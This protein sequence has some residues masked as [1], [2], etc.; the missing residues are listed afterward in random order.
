[1]DKPKTVELQWSRGQ[2]GT[3]SLSRLIDHVGAIPFQPPRHALSAVTEKFSQWS[4]G[5]IKVTAYTEQEVQDFYQKHPERHPDHP[6]QVAIEKGKALTNTLLEMAGYG[7]LAASAGGALYTLAKAAPRKAFKNQHG[8]TLFNEELL[9][10]VNIK[11]KADLNASGI[12]PAFKIIKGNVEQSL[13]KLK[14]QLKDNQTQQTYWKANS[15]QPERLAELQAQA[16]QL[17]S[18]IKLVETELSRLT[19]VATGA[20]NQKLAAHGSRFRVDDK[21]EVVVFGKKNRQTELTH[22]FE[23]AHP[24]LWASAQRGETDA[25]KQIIE[26]SLT[27]GASAENIDKKIKLARQLLQRTEHAGQPNAHNL[28]A[29]RK[30]L[31]TLEAQQMSFKLGRTYRHAAD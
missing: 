25:K 17:Q 13:Q 4:G 20:F 26:L 7:L 2:L 6:R 5:R 10:A 24:K 14:G 30:A 22:F 21:L 27:A 19:Q 23:T 9:K 31:Q 12:Y 15:Q 28:S 1:I 16:K 11:S 3:A 29:I 18:S 8:L